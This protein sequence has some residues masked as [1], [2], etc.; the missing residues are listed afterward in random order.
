[1]IMLYIITGHYGSGKTEVAVNLAVQKQV[2][3]VVDLDIVNPYFR[4]KD[5]EAY[6]ASKG[7][8]L[9]APE[10]AN[11]NL[12]LP[13]LP[14]DIYGVLQSGEDAVIDVGGDDD[15]AI[16]LGQYYPYFKEQ[17][18][19]HY[20]VVNCKRPLT[21]TPEEILET[22]ASIEA[23]SRLPVTGLIHNTHLKE[24]TT[25]DV[26]LSGEPV[27]KEVAEKTGLPVIFTAAR[28]EI[29][30]GLH[31]DTPLLPMDLHLSLPWEIR[32]EGE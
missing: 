3:T 17:D 1:M 26:V 10:F 12:D 4:T 24:L 14:P 20:V 18:F 19:S 6:L 15:G 28:R 22:I 2:K 16:A 5:A 13:T 25:P 23:A 9:I 30:D 11:T 8:R 32:K 31:M 21:E 27:I 7:I 29:C